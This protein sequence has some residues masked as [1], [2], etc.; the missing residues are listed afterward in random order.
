MTEKLRS[1]V[2]GKVREA[3]PQS[4]ARILVGG[5]GT[6]RLE[7]KLGGLLAVKAIPVRLNSEGEG[8]RIQQCVQSSSDRRWRVTMVSK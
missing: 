6:V 5:D 3:I 8:G 2:D 1:G 7:T 4:V